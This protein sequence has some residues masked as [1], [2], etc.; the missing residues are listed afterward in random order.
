MFDD[1][2]TVMPA[3]MAESSSPPKVEL[4]KLLGRFW[5]IPNMLSLSRL[6]LVLPIGYLIVT[7][8]SL[9][10]VSALVVLVVL[11]DWLDGRIARWSGSVSEW[12]KVL[13]PLADKFAGAV[14]VLALVINGSLPLW[15]LLMVIVRDL[16]IVLGG[17]ILARRIGRVAMSVMAGKAAVTV[18]ALTVLAALLRADPPLMSVLINATA[19]MMVYSFI[20]YAIRFVR[21]Y[22]YGP[23]PIDEKNPA[24]GEYYRGADHHS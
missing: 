10:F 20:V 13:D 4:S 15:L 14:I 16:L 2:R 21:M 17:I 3:R 18:L 7:E 8:G 9:V 12:G 11:T 22:R 5:T 24:M 19:V 1:L 23:L 6:F